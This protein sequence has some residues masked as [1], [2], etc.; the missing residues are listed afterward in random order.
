MAA[1]SMIYLVRIRKTC[2]REGKAWIKWI[3]LRIENQWEK[4]QNR[5][6]RKG[7]SES[8]KFEQWGN[9]QICKSGHG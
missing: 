3:R 9:H 1:I 7:D 4:W 2:L 8:Q 6:F 5:L